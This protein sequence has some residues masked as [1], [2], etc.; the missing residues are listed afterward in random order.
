MGYGYGYCCCDRIW[1]ARRALSSDLSN[2]RT[3]N[4]SWS[5]GDMNPYKGTGYQYGSG[6]FARSGVGWAHGGSLNGLWDSPI[7]GPVSAFEGRAFIYDSAS[8]LLY[9]KNFWTDFEDLYGSG[10]ASL[11]ALY[12]IPEITFGASGQFAIAWKFAF[13]G[14]TGG[15]FSSVVMTYDTDG[16]KLS[17]MATGITGVQS[18]CYDSAGKLLMKT[19]ATDTFGGPVGPYIYRFNPASLPAY[20]FSGAWE[21][22]RADYNDGGF[23]PSQSANCQMNVVDGL[24]YASGWVFEDNASLTLVSGSGLASDAGW[25]GAGGGYAWKLGNTGETY[26]LYAFPVGSYSAGSHAWAGN[27]SASSILGPLNLYAASV[28]GSDGMLLCSGRK[29]NVTWTGTLVPNL[30]TLSVAGVEGADQVAYGYDLG[31]VLDPDSWLMRRCDWV[32]W[33]ADGT[34]AL[35]GGLACKRVIGP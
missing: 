16:T 25:I 27:F 29:S 26:G 2:V 17:E 11:R 14:S 35:F 33:G 7:Y 20:A 28:R 12:I 31:N 21:V 32:Q 8:T 19:A 1:T 24:L 4:L 34:E 30:G 6:V 5:G 3:Y 10:L 15:N 18:I 13:A 23:S 9:V 22:R